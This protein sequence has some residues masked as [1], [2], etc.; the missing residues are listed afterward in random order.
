MR[1]YRINDNENIIPQ[2][3]VSKNKFYRRNDAWKYN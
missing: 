2:E 1:Q 3:I